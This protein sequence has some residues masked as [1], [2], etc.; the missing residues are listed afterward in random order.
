M[1]GKALYRKVSTAKIPESIA[2]VPCCNALDKGH[3]PHV[4][5]DPAYLTDEAHIICFSVFEAGLL[6]GIS[7]EKLMVSS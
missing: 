1:T 7:V 4:A 5:Y 6:N 3:S 2:T